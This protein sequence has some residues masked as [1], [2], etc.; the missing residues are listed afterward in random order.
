MN[1]HTPNNNGDCLLCEDK[2][3]FA[4]ET[5]QIWFLEMRNEFKDVHISCSWRDKEDQE[6]AFHEGKTKALWPHSKH[7]FE[8]DGK[9]CSLALDVFQL[10]EGKA[11]FQPKF[12]CKIHRFNQQRGYPILWGGKFRRLVD[13]DHFEMNSEII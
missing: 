10:D 1:H 11:L 8:K 5:L 13:A 9:P 7:N 12:F 6:K 3:R 2:L 4:H